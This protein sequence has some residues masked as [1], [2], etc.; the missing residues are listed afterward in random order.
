MNKT[1]RRSLVI[2]IETLTGNA[3]SYGYELA[4][5][6]NAEERKAIHDRYFKVI[7]ASWN[8]VFN[9]MEKEGK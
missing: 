2:A 9:E 6:N 8:D 1:Q 7:N 3:Y 5:A 4:R